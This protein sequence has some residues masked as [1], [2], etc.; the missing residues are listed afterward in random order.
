MKCQIFDNQLTFFISY[1]YPQ[2]T[3]KL[4]GRKLVSF[5][6]VFI[7]R[8]L[9]IINFV[10]C[11]GRSQ[12]LLINLYLCI[13]QAVKRLCILREK[14]EKENEEFVKKETE[15]KHPIQ[16]LHRAQNKAPRYPEYDPNYYHQ[17][18]YPVTST[19]VHG[20]IGI[21]LNPYSMFWLRN[22]LHCVKNV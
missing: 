7:L 20:I 1:L 10:T 22:H 6:N 15:S 18:V 5:S 11:L 14:H 2:V 21:Y 17:G 9:W 12:I 4:G 8:S 16:K 3:N 19:P 13:K